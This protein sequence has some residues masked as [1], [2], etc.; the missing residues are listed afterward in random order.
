MAADTDVV[1]YKVAPYARVVA[2]MKKLSLT[3]PLVLMVVGL[4]GAGKSFFAKQFSETFGVAHACSDRIRHE[5]FA[6][7]QFTQDENIIV[8]RIQTYFV[9]ELAKTGR[10][11]LIDGSCNAAAERRRLCEL[12]KVNGYSTLVIWVQTDPATAKA[13]SLRRSASKPD[14]QYNCGL[15]AQ[16]YDTLAKR[17]TPPTNE[18]YVVISGK[19]TYSTQARM[20]L[21][22]LA[23]PRAEAAEQAHKQKTA[24]AVAPS[25]R[26]VPKPR[27][28]N[29][30][31]R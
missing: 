17:F 12:A 20:V 10:S 23:A 29:V 21:R 24:Q 7:P 22:K 6:Q 28:R 5:L 4:P 31:I 9:D 14:D 18:D 16:Q 30:I 19:H 25:P 2:V 8:E 1:E 11:F 26:P 15:S 13:R 3:R 27:Q